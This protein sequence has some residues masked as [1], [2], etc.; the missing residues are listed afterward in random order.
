MRGLTLLLFA[1]LLNGPGAAHA[2]DQTPRFDFGWLLFGDLYY[3]PSHHTAEGDG[4]FGANMRRLYLTL[5]AKFGE[6]WYGRLRLE[7]N[8]SGEF[9]TYTYETDFKDLYVGRNLGAHKLLLGLSPTPTFDLIE[10][11]WGLRY[12]MRTPLDLQGVASRDS[13]IAARGPLNASGTLAY[14]TMV[15]AGLE[16]GNESGDG[17]KWMG[18]LN[19]RP[20]ESWTLDFYA[21][22]EKLSG[23][24]DRRTLQ[25]Y[26]GY[27]S[28]FLRWGAQYSNQAREDE[29]PLELASAYAVS[30][31]S[32]DA[33]MVGRID[34]LIEPSPKGDG[35]SYL[36]FDPSAPA[37]LFLAGFEFRAQPWLRLTPNVVVIR[38]DRNDEGVRPETDVHL[39]F[40]L[41]LDFE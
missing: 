13:G 29:P 16:F 14:R 26:V 2:Q 12:L 30:A 38:Y 21:D 15:G 31:L 35:I 23:P 10:S 9:E 25:A 4:A 11:G 6:D 18:A 22:Y 32:D 7:T 37:T 5:N 24:R 41:F 33:S 34:R 28:D 3:V 20:A 1:L 17:R 27:D 40:T 39:R 19:W 36:P 8:Q